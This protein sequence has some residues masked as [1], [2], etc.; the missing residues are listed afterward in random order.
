MA[1]TTLANQLRLTLERFATT[2]KSAGNN[3]PIILNCWRKALFGSEDKDPHFFD[4]LSLINEAVERLYGQVEGSSS[5]EEYSRKV[6]LSTLE[7]VRALLSPELFQRNVQEF[8]QNYAD[9][10][11]NL[12]GMLSSALKFERI[13]AEIPADELESLAKEI[14]GVVTGLSNAEIDA[15][16]KASLKLHASFLAWAIRNA[17]IV[18]AQGIY[19]AMMK[20]LVT[21]REIPQ[22]EIKKKGQWG[23]QLGKIYDR[24]TALIKFADSADANAHRIVQLAHD[25]QHLLQN[26]NLLK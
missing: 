24:V 16:L 2:A 15:G 3:P 9:D 25:G 4:A 13:E 11:I 8:K 21:A 12:L 10:R 19:E 6:G 26:L 5:L 18:G 17:A 20:V 22:E 1:N 7:G 23:E 14:D